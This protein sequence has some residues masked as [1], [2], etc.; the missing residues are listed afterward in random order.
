MPQDG[1]LNDHSGSSKTLKEEEDDGKELEAAHVY[2]LLKK[3]LRI[4]R[5]LRAEWYL[6]HLNTVIRVPRWTSIHELTKELE[7]VSV[8]PFDPPADFDNDTAH[9][10]RFQITRRT[11]V[12]CLSRKY[13]LVYGLDLSPSMC[14]VILGNDGRAHVLLD[15]V[16]TAL[17]DAIR[18]VLQ[19]FFVPGSELMFYPVVYVTVLAHTNLFRCDWQLVLVQGWYLMRHNLDLFLRHLKERLNKLNMHLAETIIKLNL[20]QPPLEASSSPHGRPPP[21]P[22][23]HWSVDG[24]SS[25]DADLDVSL[26]Q[27][28]DPAVS[29]SLLSRGSR[30][31]QPSSG[32]FTSSTLSNFPSYVTRTSSPVR[33]MKPPSCTHLHCESQVNY[34][35][36][37]DALSRHSPLRLDHSGLRRSPGRGRTRQ[38]SEGGGSVSSEDASKRLP[39]PVISSDLSLVNLLRY[40]VVALQ[41]L[42]ERSISGIVV[43]TDGVCCMSNVSFFDAF[44]NHMR[45]S[46]ISISFLHLTSK[47]TPIL[48]PPSAS[49]F[50]TPSGSP[51][52]KKMYKFPNPEIRFHSTADAS[53][54]EGRKESSPSLAQVARTALHRL[55]SY[56]VVPERRMVEDDFN[57][58]DASSTASLTRQQ[59]LQMREESLWRQSTVLLSRKRSQSI[60]IHTEE[61]TDPSDKEE[62]LD[63][64]ASEDECV[65]EE[66]VD[67]SEKWRTSWSGKIL[68]HGEKSLLKTERSFSEEPEL[69]SEYPFDSFSIE[70]SFQRDFD[71]DAAFEEEVF[72]CHAMRQTDTDSFSDTY[73]SESSVTEIELLKG[74][75]SEACRLRRQ[76]KYNE[77]GNIFS[78]KSTVPNHHGRTGK[79]GL[80]SLE[81][82]DATNRFSNYILGSAEGH[83]PVSSEFPARRL[84]ELVTSVTDFLPS[85]MRPNPHL[86]PGFLDNGTQPSSALGASSSQ[87]TIPWGGWDHRHRS[88]NGEDEDDDGDDDDDDPWMDPGNDHFGLV[89]YTDLLKFLA[90]ATGGAYMDAVPQITEEY[91]YAMSLYHKTFLCWDFQQLGLMEAWGVQR[92]SSASSLRANK[93][94]HRSSTCVRERRERLDCTARTLLSCRLREGFRV[95]AVDEQ[96]GRDAVALTLPWKHGVLFHYTVSSSK[97]RL[98]NKDSKAP[99]NNPKASHKDSKLEGSK[100]RASSKDKDLRVRIELHVE[101]PYEFLVDLEK[102]DQ[103]KGRVPYRAQQEMLGSEYR[104]QLVTKYRSAVRELKET[105]ELLVRLHN[106]ACNSLHY[107][108]PQHSTRGLPFF[109]YKPNVGLVPLNESGVSSSV[110]EFWR[111]LCLLEVGAWHKWL[112]THRIGLVLEHDAPL[113]RTL[114]SYTN[115]RF[116]LVQCRLAELTLGMLLAKWCHFV[117]LEGQTYVKFLYKKDFESAKEA[118]NDNSTLQSSYPG[119]PPPKDGG[120]TSRSL[121]VCHP[122]SRSHDSALADPSDFALTGKTTDSISS[123]KQFLDDLGESFLKQ[124]YTSANKSDSADSAVFGSVSNRDSGLETMNVGSSVDFSLRSVSNFTP[125]SSSMSGITSSRKKDRRKCVTTKGDGTGEP[126]VP[127]SFILVRISPAKPPC[128]TVRLAFL[129][130]TPGVVRQKLVE[131]LRVLVSRLTLPVRP[132]HGRKWLQRRVP[133]STFSNG[134]SAPG[135]PDAFAPSASPPDTF[136]SVLGAGISA[137]TGGDQAASGGG[138]GRFNVSPA[139]S[140]DAPAT[141]R[142]MSS[143]AARGRAGPD[144]ASSSA[145]LAAKVGNV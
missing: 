143:G 135:P 4:S 47:P 7:V 53:L 57:S 87:P 14:R 103:W 69:S 104:Y 139:G 88:K 106:F 86:R 93:V 83:Y 111:P 48:E 23:D 58:R 125:S 99:I 27:S 59:M 105:D 8:E 55:A 137:S 128:I 3:D 130:G 41:L 109:Y 11:A 98:P 22:C 30:L 33:R 21:P 46:T 138:V 76:N 108:V 28:Y 96:Q 75:I 72:G 82:F 144:G 10:Y 70:D 56:P 116:G 80:F 6:E 102:L 120:V 94:E 68:W 9:E 32:S 113:P 132:R 134:A 112:H 90:S 20:K 24:D 145:A 115:N 12:H 5:N 107:T 60:E 81:R 131:E 129:G 118:S 74:A 64:F 100:I 85:Q 49:P 114:H 2:L 110:Y 122:M 142:V 1:Q 89:S 43:I 71:A 67:L 52:L 92:P 91:D 77:R 123:T 40:C 54:L 133:A 42:P 17:A 65:G 66:S 78:D 31:D 45:N 101:A 140:R 97:I 119:S 136:S 141:D 25:L 62:A 16:H 15:K 38:L 37:L 63:Y 126:E 73:V 127:L 39:E 117:L 95:R 18:G 51:T 19:P 79:S 84:Q 29:H 44:L 35:K 36:Y 50:S 13:R 34:A 61:L 26:D 124:H 121:T